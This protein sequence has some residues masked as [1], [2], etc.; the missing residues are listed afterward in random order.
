MTTA[1]T[2]RTIESEETWYICGWCGLEQYAVKGTEPPVP[3]VDCGWAHRE[4]KRYD[5]PSEIKLDLT[6]Y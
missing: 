1:R 5:L 2:K 6:K 4:K 3:C